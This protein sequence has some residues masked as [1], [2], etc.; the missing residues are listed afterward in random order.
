[1]TSPRPHRLHMV[2]WARTQLSE[3]PG[4]GTS[5]FPWLAAKATCAQISPEVYRD[6]LVQDSVSGVAAVQSPVLFSEVS[7]L[8]PFFQ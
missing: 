4:Q 1:M 8:T 3:L 7:L 6:S 5:S 2:D